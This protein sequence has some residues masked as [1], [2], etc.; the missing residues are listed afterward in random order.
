MMVEV[1]SIDELK[2]AISSR[3]TEVESHAEELVKKLQMYLIDK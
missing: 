3:A 2:K 1:N